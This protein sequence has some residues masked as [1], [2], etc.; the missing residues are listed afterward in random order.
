MAYG[1]LPQIS[2]FVEVFSTGILTKTLSQKK[3]YFFS[4]YGLNSFL[5]KTHYHQALH[6]AEVIATD[7][8]DKQ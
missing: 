4:C 1:L 2:G 3:N 6:K 5:Y 8:K 7:K